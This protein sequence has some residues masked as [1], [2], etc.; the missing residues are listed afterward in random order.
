V[1]FFGPYPYRSPF[2]SDRPEQETERA[3]HHLEQVFQ[4]QG[5]NTVGA[6]FLE[7]VVCTAGI[8]V[9]LLGYLVGVRALADDYN[10]VWIADETMSCFARTGNWFVFQNWEAQSDSDLLRQ[11]FRTPVTD[12]G[13]GVGY[14]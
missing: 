1:H 7:S 2:W 9:P 4:F 14:L 10:I 3:L 8:L 5:P 12:L 11:G 6:I 13:A